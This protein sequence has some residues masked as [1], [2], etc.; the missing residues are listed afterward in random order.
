[1]GKKEPGI[2]TGRGE[3]GGAAALNSGGSEVEVFV[4]SSRLLKMHLQPA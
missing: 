4:V 2:G 1:M 3:D